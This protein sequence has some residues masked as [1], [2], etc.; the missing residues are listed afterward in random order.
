MLQTGRHQ[1][2]PHED[3]EDTQVATDGVR[4]VG[5]DRFQHWPF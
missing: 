5:D 4:C 2:K 3:M 1:P